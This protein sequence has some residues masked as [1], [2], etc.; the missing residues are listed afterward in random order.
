MN[1]QMINLNNEH[2]V[3]LVIVIYLCMCLFIYVTKLQQYNL[4][5]AEQ[6]ITKYSLS[7]LTL[8][9]FTEQTFIISIT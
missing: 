2:S 9:P 8:N 6:K 3:S 5:N 1:R 7:H 4:H